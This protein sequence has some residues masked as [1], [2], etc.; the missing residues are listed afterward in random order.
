MIKRNFSKEK[1][2][3]LI[4]RQVFSKLN[5]LQSKVNAW[6]NVK[7]PI[8]LS[9]LF[10]TYLYLNL[11]LRTHFFTINS[12]HLIQRQMHFQIFSQ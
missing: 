9:H 4:Q 2:A 12:K 10:S 7:Y 1:L 8:S 3:H 6:P 11:F 5:S